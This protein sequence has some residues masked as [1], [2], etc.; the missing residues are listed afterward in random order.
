MI[1]CKSVLTDPLITYWRD[2][3]GVTL[4][5]NLEEKNG[6]MLGA[7]L[8]SIPTKDNGALLVRTGQRF[9]SSQIQLA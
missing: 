4:T 6:Q 7:T 2:E 3:N 5:A 1:Y 9:E 8:D